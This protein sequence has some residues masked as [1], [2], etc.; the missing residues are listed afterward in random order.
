MFSNYILIMVKSK[1]VFSVLIIHYADSYKYNDVEAEDVK[2]FTTLKKA[3]LCVAQRID[4]QIN[5]LAREH[6]E[7][8]E[9]LDGTDLINN[10]DDENQLK[11]DTL[12]D[13]DTME[14]LHKLLLVGEYVDYVMEYKIQM[15]NIF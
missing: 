2:L 15:L 3:Q 10:F 8:K 7:L 5:E 1:N 4:G 6:D 9:I 13:F 11:K 12:K 14:Q